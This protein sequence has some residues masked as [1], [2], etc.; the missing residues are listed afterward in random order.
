MNKL[1]VILPLTSSIGVMKFVDRLTKE[2]ELSY[3]VVDLAKYSL[4]DIK[5]FLS[6]Y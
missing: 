5:R 1:A 4:D 3:K 6:E 2:K